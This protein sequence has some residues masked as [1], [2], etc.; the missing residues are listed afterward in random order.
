MNT[1]YTSPFGNTYDLVSYIVN[2]YVDK[3]FI[4]VVNIQDPDRDLLGYTGRVYQT[5]QENIKVGK[6]TIKQ[7]TLYYTE[8]NRLVGK[9]HKEYV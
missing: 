7:G 1:T 5:A 2:Y 3:K 6:K 8:L 4:G 9:L